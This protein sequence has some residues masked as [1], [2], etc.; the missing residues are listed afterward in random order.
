M[1][2]EIMTQTAIGK[3]VDNYDPKGANRIRVSLF[4]LTN[5]LSPDDLPFYSIKPEVSDTPN[6]NVK[7]PPYGSLV[8]VE[9]KDDD[10]YN[11]VVVSTQTAIPPK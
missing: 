5:D 6:S 8:E 7:I 11:G 3:V 9:I 1:I 4:G 10:I 2:E